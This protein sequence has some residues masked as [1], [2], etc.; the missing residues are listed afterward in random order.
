MPF[1]KHP[2]FEFSKMEQNIWRYLS[3]TDLLWVCQEGKL[4][5]HRT[6]DFNDPYEGTVPK[7]VVDN[8]AQILENPE[9]DI[10]GS[11]QDFEK[12]AKSDSI[13]ARATMFANC[14]HASDSESA[15]MWEQYRKDGKPV[16]IKSSISS[17]IDAVEKIEQPIHIGEVKYVDHDTGLKGLGEE[18]R[19]SLESLYS[20]TK[21]D[22]LYYPILTKRKEFRHE[23]EIRAVFT[24]NE[25]FEELREGRSI[26]ID[27]MEKLAEDYFNLKVDVDSLIEEIYIGPNI[28]N[29]TVDTMRE[30]ISSMDIGSSIEVTRS[31][32]NNKPLEY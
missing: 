4:H 22:A 8:R 26:E 28:P 31:T 7:A 5:F 27:E 3:F 24:D 6:G 12:R 13:H 23:S 21:F 14:W 10:D 17:L 32:M 25:L 2:I 15:A 16:C 1:E 11:R 30:V 18:D 9:W 20:R 29:R 19:K